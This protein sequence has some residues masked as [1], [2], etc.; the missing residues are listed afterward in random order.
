MP[1]PRWRKVLRD[2]WNNKTRTVLVVLS[3]AV[4]VFAVGMIAGTQ[5]I[6]S[7]ELPLAYA[8]VHPSSAVLYTSSFDDDTLAA[9][10][11]VEGVRA[12]EG[13]R[14][15]NVR[16]KV[17]EPLPPNSPAWRDVRMEANNNFDGVEVD[18]VRH[19]QGAWP[20]PDRELLIERNSLP[21]LNA[22]IGDTVQVETPDGKQ[23]SL[24]VAGTTHDL[25]KPPAAFTGLAFAYANFTTLEWLGFARDYDELHIVVAGNATDREHITTVANRVRDKLRNGGISVNFI[26]VPER[27]GEHP[28][29]DTIQTFL[30]ILGVLG[31]LSLFL[32]GFLVVNTMFSILAQQVRQIGMMKA[33]GALTGQVVALYLGGVLVYGML[34]LLVAVPLGGI[35]A[36]AMS[37]FIAGLVNFDLR[38]FSIPMQTLALEIAVGLV[39]PT[40]AALAPVLMGARVSVREAVNNYGL[41]A[42][43]FGGNL[44]DRL[45]ERVRFLSRPLLL[46]LRNTFR[47][48]SR[49]ALTLF[50]LT[51]GGAI[52]IAVI[53]VQASLARTLDDALAYWAYDIDVDLAS[54][55]RIDQLVSEAQSVPGVVAAE[56]WSGSGVR[57]LRTDKSES[58]NYSMLA[59]DAETKLLRPFVLA[60]RWLVPDDENAVVVNSEIMKN[61]ADLK[62]GDELTL[63]L[64][65]KDTQWRVVGIVR[66]VLTGPIIYVNYPYFARLSH[67]P[68]RAGSVQVLT[69]EHDR[70][71]QAAVAAAL[72]DRFDAIGLRVSRTQTTSQTRDNIEYQFAILVVFMAI[73]AVL[74]A[75]V[76]GLGLTGTMSI[77]VLERSREIG[78][79][80]AIGASN[81]AVLQI[82]LVEGLLIGALSWAIGALLSL[83]ISRLLSD[84]IGTTFMRAPLSFTFSTTGA[85]EWLALVAMLS[86]LASF[87]P[88]WRAMRLSVR[89]VLAYE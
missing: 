77:N 55:H 21:L 14:R 85:L 89:E 58:Q 42:G 19:E 83:P 44:I 60:G 82:F 33:V 69:R 46:S 6:M 86:T 4:G 39:A 84:V 24:T 9:I 35:A 53:T 76:G 5:S 87:L 70:A 72:K 23:R 34:S 57:R 51:L 64:N 52:F 74:L 38:P 71:S 75:V 11:R 17:M 32:S 63:K 41:S 68:G 20:P 48:K 16:I 65:E 66:A 50:T 2:L 12:A 3:I 43:K 27:P 56:S 78:V 49:L 80:R 47:R 13:R 36:Y 8:Q 40:L 67:S 10:R 7:A 25:N 54:S 59:T 73:M 45:L 37:A 15:A 79:M 61:E 22:Q 29:N 31:T 30:V 62:V 26:Y 1:S 81:G 18:I 88:A 28:A